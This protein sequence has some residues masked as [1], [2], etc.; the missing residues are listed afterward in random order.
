MILWV[1]GTG[2]TVVLKA[3]IPDLYWMAA[4]TSY[5]PTM[6]IRQIW[7]DTGVAVLERPSFCPPPDA[8]QTIFGI[9]LDKLPQMVVAVDH[10]P[11]HSLEVPHL[12]ISP[13]ALSALCPE[14]PQ[15]LL[16]PERLGWVVSEMQTRMRAAL[17]D[18]KDWTR[19]QTLTEL[20]GFLKSVL[21]EEAIVDFI[22]R[23][24]L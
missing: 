17:A 11:P 2:K 9:N 21:G 5:P 12:T 10:G 22:L 20:R 7:T 15:T 24:S 14:L 3:I 1:Y 8:P 6:G 4:A 13:K 23:L 18:W 16:G 19:L